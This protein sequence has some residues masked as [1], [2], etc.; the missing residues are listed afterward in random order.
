[1]PTIELASASVRTQG[2]GVD[3]M[4]VR[5][6]A[7]GRRLLSRRKHPLSLTAHV[8]FA[9]A[10]KPAQQLDGPVAANH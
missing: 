9:A 4:T 1:M 5:L 8:S 10:D 7:A 3:V 6:S 2:A